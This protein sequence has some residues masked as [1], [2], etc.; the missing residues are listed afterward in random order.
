MLAGVEAAR[1]LLEFVP[2]VGGHLA[3]STVRSH[4]AVHRGLML[5]LS[6]CQQEP[7]PEPEPVEEPPLA[8]T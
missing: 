4:P 8:V 6:A 2:A 1:V 7:E 3:A 5:T